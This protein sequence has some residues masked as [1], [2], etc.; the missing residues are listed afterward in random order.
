MPVAIKSCLGLSGLAWLLLFMAFFLTNRADAQFSTV[1]NI[2]GVRL[3]ASITSD[4]QLNVN[5]GGRV[6]SNFD[7]GTPDGLSSNI[8]VN[9]IGGILDGNFNA[10]S[11]STINILSGLVRDNFNAYSGS[12]INISGGSVGSG[13][14]ANTG[15]LVNVSGGTIGD[16]FDANTGSTINISEG[17]I[18]QS[19]Q[20]NAGS[21]LNISG[22]TFGQSFQ[23]NSGSTVN[24]ADGTFGKGFVI[25][26]GSIVNYSGGSFESF[27]NLSYSDPH[28]LTTEVGSELNISGSRFF[29]NDT[30][31]T[32][33][34]NE[35]PT[36]AVELSTGSALS[37]YAETGT[38]FLFL[39]RIYWHSPSFA[40]GTLTINETENIAPESKTIV[41]DS[42]SLASY[43][44]QNQNYIVTENGQLES[45]VFRVGN[46]N[47]ISIEGGA[48]RTLEAHPNTN[49]SVL[50]G[51]I[52]GGIYSYGG[53]ASIS[54][55]EVN[56][57][58]WADLGANVT[59]N[60][61]TAES[62]LAK[63]FSTVIVNGGNYGSVVASNSAET[64][65]V[66]GGTL[67]FNDGVAENLSAGGNGKIYIRGGNITGSNIYN[68]G[69]EIVISGG[70]VSGDLNLYGTKLT[71][72]GGNINGL[73]INDHDNSFPSSEV[74]FRGT[75]F[76]SFSNIYRDNA[77]YFLGNEAGEIVQLPKEDVGR[78]AFDIYGV[79]SDGTPFHRSINNND[80]YYIDSA[81]TFEKTELVPRERVTTVLVNESIERDILG[82]ETIDLFEGGIGS[83]DRDLLAGTG[84]M[85]N[86]NRSV[87]SDNF[88]GIGT[89]LTMKDSDIGY[90]VQLV[91]GSKLDFDG[92][93]IRQ[94]FKAHDHTILNIQNAEIE[95]DFEIFTG[96]IANITSSRIT[97]WAR[98]FSGSQINISDNSYVEGI[99]AQPGGTVNIRDGRVDHAVVYGRNEELNNT[100]PGVLNISGGVVDQVSLYRGS[101]SGAGGTINASLN[102]SGGKINSFFDNSIFG[103]VNV[104]G[105]Q[106]LTDGYDV[107]ELLPG[108]SITLDT[109]LPNLTAILA[110]GTEMDLT[111]TFSFSR[112]S[113]TLTLLPEDFLAGDFN[114]DGK[115]DGEDYYVWQD[116]IGQ[117]SS[118]LPN[119]FHSGIVGDAEIQTW[120]DNFGS[121]LPEPIAMPGDYNDD[122]VV[123]AADYTVLRDHYGHDAGTLPNDPN[124]GKIGDA[125]YQTWVVNLVSGLKE[126]IAMPGDYNGD[127]VVDAADYTVLRD[128]YGHDAGT[129]PND[130]NFGIIGEAQYQT[131][132]ANYGN[133]LEIPIASSVAIPEPSALLLMALST[134]LLAGKRR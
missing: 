109:N 117:D 79:F 67:Y 9:L 84:S 49:L 44:T 5:E 60:D 118:L 6:A 66:A 29:L 13:F 108:E 8:E 63:S 31:I 125:Q 27:A 16:N 86:M 10:Y 92:G 133:T 14:N 62:V 45:P 35:N 72:E 132:V 46:G 116:H 12:T 38:P 3:G 87:I 122:G 107:P 70:E 115:V 71:I 34:T 123:D 104:I 59:V 52:T 78:R 11:G 75:H 23:A 96:S 2:P 127:G 39:Q 76:Y 106:F 69:G 56:G 58:I 102:I 100:D 7:S 15:S 91:G 17:T 128:H 93:T 41:I 121:V 53:V 51:T 105:K 48:T 110:D 112:S 4:T 65:A 73:N 61:S 30:P 42:N 129:L 81:V 77:S 33:G 55:S 131:W 19:F 114:A 94:N 54:N 134:P 95:P 126:S 85:I 57:D 28:V 26:E 37:G 50:N 80:D 99:D 130:P 97:A 25:K 68:Y 98:S 74:S 113:L 101:F 90:H 103:K 82:H 32:V 43:S 1:I 120:L 21:T 119:N 20:A 83:F 24:I 36:L 18:G 111:S 64:D 22:A 47:S 40:A 89:T 124:F 88:V